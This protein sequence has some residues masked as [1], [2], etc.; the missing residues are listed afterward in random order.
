[1]F[2]SKLK[3]STIVILDALVV[4]LTVATLIYTFY[5]AHQ[6]GELFEQ[7][8]QTCVLPSQRDAMNEAVRS[9]PSFTEFLSDEFGGVFDG[10]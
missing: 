10:D 4:V 9:L 7:M 1:M 2:S 3:S 6:Y 8:R 5:W